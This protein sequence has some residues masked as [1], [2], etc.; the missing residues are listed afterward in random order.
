MAGVN[1]AVEAGGG[2]KIRSAVSSNARFVCGRQRAD[3]HRMSFEVK[4][5]LSISSQYFPS[6]KMTR[7]AVDI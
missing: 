2:L 5:I 7:A 6:D 1:G 3:R 4:L